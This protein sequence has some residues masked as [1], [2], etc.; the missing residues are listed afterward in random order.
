MI[1]FKLKNLSFQTIEIET[2]MGQDFDAK[3]YTANILR[4]YGLTP[5]RNA[6]TGHPDWKVYEKGGRKFCIEVKLGTDGL[7][8]NQVEWVRDHPDI[9]VLVF[10]IKTLSEKNQYKKL[11][12]ERE[13]KSNEEKELKEIGKEAFKIIR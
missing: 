3:N 4:M 8:K 6:E 9:E 13:K 10:F 7:H 12:K 2:G 1:P 11:K 5:V